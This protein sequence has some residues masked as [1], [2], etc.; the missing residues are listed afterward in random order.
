MKKRMLSVLLSLVMLTGMLPQTAFAMRLYDTAGILNTGMHCEDEWHG[1]DAVV[2]LDAGWYGNDEC[3]EPDWYYG[4]DKDDVILFSS[5]IRTYNRNNTSE[6]LRRTD[7]SPSR[8][9]WTVGDVRCFPQSG[10]GACNPTNFPFD[11]RLVDVLDSLRDQFGNSVTVKAGDNRRGFRCSTH[12]WNNGKHTLGLAVDVSAAAATNGAIYDFAVRQPGVT[13]LSSGSGRNTASTNQSYVV[14]PNARGLGFVHISV[15]PSSSSAA[16]SQPRVSAPAA[17]QRSNFWGGVR[18]S[19]QA[20]GTPSTQ[21]LRFEVKRNGAGW[22]HLGTDNSVRS[23]SRGSADL[24]TAGTFQWRVSARASGFTNSSFSGDSSFFFTVPQA[25]QPTLSGVQYDTNN[26]IF[27]TV[28]ANGNSSTTRYFYRIST[29]GSDPG[30]P[31]VNSNGTAGANTHRVPDNMHIP[32]TQNNTRISVVAVRNGAVISNRRTSGVLNIQSPAAPSVSRQGAEQVNTGS[33]VA[34]TWTASARAVDYQASLWQGN[35]NIRTLTWQTGR[36]ASF[37]L[38][39]TAGVYEVRVVARNAAGNS[40]AGRTTFTAMSPVFIT[41]PEFPGHNTAVPWNTRLPASVF[42]QNTAKEGHDFVRWVANG[43]LISPNTLLTSNITINAEY[44]I[45]SYDVEF[46]REDGTLIRSDRVNHGSS[47]TPPSFTPEPR[48]SFTGWTPDFSSPNFTGNSYE[49]VTANTRFAASTA[50]ADPLLP[51]ALEVI[52]QPSL[53]EAGNITEVEI[54]VRFFRQGG[55]DEYFAAGQGARL[56]AVVKDANG[57]VL[58]SE[59]RTITRLSSQ[60][61]DENVRIAVPRFNPD[62][63]NSSNPPASA[64]FVILGTTGVMTGGALSPLVDVNLPVSWGPEVLHTSAITPIPGIREVRAAA[65]WRHRDREFRNSV[66]PAAVVGGVTWELVRHSSG[67]DYTIVSESWGTWQRVNPAPTYSSVQVLANGNRVYNWQHRPLLNTGTRRLESDFRRTAPAQ[68]RYYVDTWID[69]E[70]TRR[71]AVCIWDFW[72]RHDRGRSGWR[73]TFNAEYRRRMAETLRRDE[74]QWDTRRAAPQP[75]SEHSTSTNNIRCQGANQNNGYCTH[76]NRQLNT[77]NRDWRMYSTALNTWFRSASGGN[78]RPD[79]YFRESFRD[80]SPEVRLLTI[81]PRYDFRRWRDWTDWSNTQPA[82]AGENRQIES[83][84]VWWVRQAGVSPAPIDVPTHIINKNL[85]EFG[86]QSTI[87]LNN[88]EFTVL[89]WQRNNVDPFTALQYMGSGKVGN[90]G[91]LSFP[92]RP[93]NGNPTKETGDFIVGIAF[94]RQ[95]ALLIVDTIPAPVQTTR[96]EF[97]NRTHIEAVDTGTEEI[98]LRPEDLVMAKYLLPGE[99]LLPPVIPPLFGYYLMGWREFSESEDTVRIFAPI[100]EPREYTLVLANFEDDNVGTAIELQYFAYGVNIY[101][102]LPT[103][104]SG[105]RSRFLGWCYVSDNEGGLEDTPYV[106][107]QPNDTMPAESI[108]LIA[109]WEPREF[110]VAFVNDDFP[111]DFF[112]DCDCVDESLESCPH[113]RDLRTIPDRYLAEGT[114]RRQTVK[115]GEAAALPGELTVTDNRIFHG[116]SNDNPWWNVTGDLVVRPIVTYTQTAPD[117]GTVFPCTCWEDI[118]YDGCE[119]EYIWQRVRRFICAGCFDLDCRDCI[120]FAAMMAVGIVVEPGSTVNA[121]LALIGDSDSVYHLSST[122]TGV[123]M[124]AASLFAK[125]NYDDMSELFVYDENHE[126]FD[127]YVRLFSDDW[128]EEEIEDLLT[129]YQFTEDTVIW[130]NSDVVLTMF[131]SASGMNDSEFVVIN[132]PFVLED[133]ET[134]EYGTFLTT[135]DFL[136]L[137]GDRIEIPVWISNP[138]ALTGTLRALFNSNVFTRIETIPSDAAEEGLLATFVFEVRNVPVN[139]YEIRFSI[140][141]QN[142]NPVEEILPAT[143]IVT[144]YD[145]ADPAVHVQA[146]AARDGY[147][148]VTVSITG[149]PG[150]LSYSMQLYF[151]SV[152]LKPV[153]VTRGNNFG[154]ALNTNIGMHG[155][156]FINASWF[157][158]EPID[159]DDVLFTVRFQLGDNIEFDTLP[160]FLVVTHIMD[161]EGNEVS[162]RAYDDEII[163]PPSNTPSCTRLLGDANGDGVVDGRDL[164]YIARY[165]ASWAGY[166]PHC[167]KCIDVNGDGVFDG[168]DLIFFARHL[169]GWPGYEVLGTR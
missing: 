22:T 27:V 80:A 141:N 12:K 110:V 117:P 72:N 133:I 14:N 114:L 113:V 61:R 130:V 107:V 112:E 109:A 74:T 39:S 124:L 92:V 87:P 28:G 62:I 53:R 34:I 4:V 29:N 63:G 148:D 26:R 135:R 88:L 144:V 42:P 166:D 169:A 97:Y 7:G 99:L 134:M 102:T 93:R 91:E 2:D 16:S 68:Y 143:A 149:N 84:P 78:P 95:S 120:D 35:T 101:E 118:D 86:I 140:V 90:N 121:A 77:D 49:R 157:N 58:T 52:G 55:A 51:M 100:W 69:A 154:G 83:R 24:R 155:I 162:V 127:N 13:R 17:R 33:N 41:F 163:V 3:N 119:C 18:L 128:E 6:L 132:V 147:V 70:G 103:P 136:A 131:S 146:E 36:T 142:Q 11:S 116:W 46:R 85:S 159:T 66:N 105:R 167:E 150:I 129:F 30:V 96:V 19:A 48:R 37:A 164:I 57:T 138:Y 158:A 145:L 75:R 82:A 137:P 32:I 89:V 156:S 115:W 43:Q 47:I 50:W 5:T 123:S 71:R 65:Q 125:P 40:T 8:R 153:S 1:F 81:T 108:V 45:R 59:S 21:N 126:K 38:P 64:K 98:V 111:D 168:R 56:V 161:N 15:A 160:M 104:I 31:N 94:P 73:G 54:N 152:N 20:T 44:R 23:G 106:V 25:E 60:P 79:A 10:Q 76:G 165:I 139:R 9:G 151:D 122:P 67:R